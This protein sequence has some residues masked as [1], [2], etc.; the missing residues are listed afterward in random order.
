MTTPLPL[1]VLGGFLGAGKTT[2]VNRL[3]AGARGVRLAVLVNDFGAVSIDQ[4]LI[5]GRD[6]QVVTLAN[7]CICCSLQQDLI[8][9]V[10]ELAARGAGAFDHLLIEASGLSDPSQLLRTLGHPRLRERIS[11]NC[12][13]TV[14]DAARFSELDGAARALAE[15]QLLG[16]DIA[17]L[18][19]L[20]AAGEAPAEAARAHL[21]EAGVRCLDITDVAALWTVLLG[22]EHATA[23]ERRYLPAAPAAA[24]Q[25][26]HW[27]F[28]PAGTC[29]LHA[30]RATLASLPVQIYR[31]KGFVRVREA[32]GLRCTVQVVGDRVDIRRAGGDSLPGEDIL[33]FVAARGRVDW[34]DVTRRL[35]GCLTAVRAP[36][37]S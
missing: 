7:G 20:D 24:D 33:V 12:C 8:T 1:T 2:L 22:Q 26:E 13:A 32:E 34:T 5:A 17:L 28:E 31:A 11:I 3:L 10:E 37:P 36:G 35:H 23:Q 16:A 6:A 27:S 18:S 15:Q 14:L 29:E 4:Y 19:K 21:R 30:L 25:F 9:Q